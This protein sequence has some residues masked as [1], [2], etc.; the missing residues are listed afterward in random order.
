MPQDKFLVFL[1]SLTTEENKGLIEAI[2]EGYKSILENKFG[3]PD[4]FRF[5]GK[6]ETLESKV[7]KIADGLQIQAEKMGESYAI[8]D[9]DAIVGAYKQGKMELAQKLY[10]RLPITLKESSLGQT[11]GKILYV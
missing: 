2:T 4:E 10:E 6:A 11:L 1:E 3:M 8:D 7:A 5:R 9:L